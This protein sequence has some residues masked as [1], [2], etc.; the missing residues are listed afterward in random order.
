MTASQSQGHNIG[1]LLVSEDGE[2]LSW[3]VND[4]SYRH[5]EVNTLVN[6]YLKNPGASRLPKR[7]VLFTTLKPC[8]MCSTY[9]KESWDAPGEA[10]MRSGRNRAIVAAFGFRPHGAAAP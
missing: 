2:V 1:S 3:G 10:R 6:Y 9:I 4:G 8:A 7:S 5:A